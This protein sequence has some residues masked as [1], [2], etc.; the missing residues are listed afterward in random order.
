MPQVLTT[1]A[2]ILCPHGGLA[3]EHLQPIRNGLSMEAL[4]YS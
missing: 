4:C 1:N 3:Y 2:L